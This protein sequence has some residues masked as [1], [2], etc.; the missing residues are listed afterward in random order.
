MFNEVELIQVMSSG[1]KNG[2]QQTNK[3]KVEEKKCDF[4]VSSNVHNLHSCSFHPLVILIFCL[5]CY[6]NSKHTLFPQSLPSPSW[7]MPVLSYHRK[8]KEKK[9]CVCVLL[10]V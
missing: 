7:S 2:H 3:K 1:D 9:V 5:F 10:V 6:C 4:D 8:S